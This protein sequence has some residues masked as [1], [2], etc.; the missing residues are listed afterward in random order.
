MKIVTYKCDFCDVSFYEEI[1]KIIVD[2]HVYHVCNDCFNKIS[3]LIK[4]ET[5]EYCIKNY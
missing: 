3:V 4:E 5:V 2:E 1:K